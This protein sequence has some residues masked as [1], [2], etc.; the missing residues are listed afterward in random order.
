MADLT[1]DMNGNK[2][3]LKMDSIEKAIDL[4]DIMI[5]QAKD[6]IFTNGINSVSNNKWTKMKFAD[7]NTYHTR[8][9]SIYYTGK[10]IEKYSA[11]IKED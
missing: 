2:T 1:L 9:W 3:T 8:S 10:R 5:S 4:V 7:G 11:T 6:K